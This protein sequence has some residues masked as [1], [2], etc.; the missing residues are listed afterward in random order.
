[1]D[2]RPLKLNV[3]A[4]LVRTNI[5]HQHCQKFVEPCLYLV[6]KPTR[7]CY[8]IAAKHMGMFWY[9]MV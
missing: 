9:S 2:D 8:I 3:T 7:L 1:M 6:S 4:T 5:L